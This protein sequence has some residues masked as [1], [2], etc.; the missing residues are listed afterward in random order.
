MLISRTSIFGTLRTKDLP[1]TEE[2]YTAWQSGVYAQ[3]AFPNLNASDREFIISGNTTEDWDRI[4][5]TNLDDV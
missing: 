4:F 3:D 5:A 1:I 2:Q